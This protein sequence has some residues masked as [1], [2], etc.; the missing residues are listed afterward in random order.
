MGIWNLGGPKRK[1]FLFIFIQLEDAL[2]QK[3]FFYIYLTTFQ[4]ISKSRTNL[5]NNQ[6]IMK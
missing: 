1:T 5:K 6:K 4:A 3:V 2:N